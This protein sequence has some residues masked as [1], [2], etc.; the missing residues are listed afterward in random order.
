MLR[1]GN[2]SRERRIGGWFGREIQAGERQEEGERSDT[3]NTCR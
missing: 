2:T 3:R 1:Q